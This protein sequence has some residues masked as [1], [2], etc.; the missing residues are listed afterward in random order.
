MPDATRAGALAQGR[1]SW[2]ADVGL[3]TNPLLLRQFGTLLAVTG[4]VMFGL[5]SLLFAVQGE[6]ESIPMA[7]LATLVG[8]GVLALLMLVVVL[9]FFGNRFRARFAVSETGV[10][11]ET[12]DRRAKAANRLAALLGVLGGS[13]ST[14]GAGM[15]GLSRESEAYGWRGIA[16]ATYYPRS[17]SIALRNR[18]R[19]VAFLA[20]T[21]GNYD[22]VAAFVRQHLADRAAAGPSPLPRLLGRTLLV[23]V[24]SLPVFLLPYPFELD[25]LLPLI[26]LCFALATVWLVHLFGWVV[27]ATALLIAA[28]IVLIALGTRE[29]MFAWRGAYRTYEILDTSDWL[30]LALAAVGLVYLVVSSWRA[31]RGR[32]PSALS[33][34][35][36]EGEE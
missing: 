18:W 11:F 5:L 34:D 9:L 32:V 35:Y 28:Q 26:M 29:S 13:S 30:A 2:E 17:H 4:L 16:V 6:W 33:Q 10:S 23:I 24:A 36:A 1:L 8:V 20:C 7:L 27:I 21:P 3:L 14:A 31:A 25:L 15:I 12:V 19:M 22:Q